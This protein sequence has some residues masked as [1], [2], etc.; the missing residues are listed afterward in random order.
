V[1]EYETRKVQPNDQPDYE[2]DAGLGGP[3]PIISR[4]LGDLRFYASYR[5]SRDMLILPLS[6]PDYSS[7]DW[8]VQVSSDITPSLKLKLSAL[9][10]KQFTQRH[11]WDASNVAGSYFYP[12]YPNEVANV[13]STLGSVSDLKNV[14]SDFNFSITD[15]GQRSLVAKVT[16]ILSS[17]TFY[18]VSIENFQRDYYT[19]PPEMRDTSK[20]YEII[21]GFFEDSN[22]FGYWP[23]N[24]SNS[25]G[26]TTDVMHICKARDN[27]VT[28]ATTLK[29]DFTSQVNF[30]NLVKG[31]L[32]FV[33]NDL[34]F[35]YGVISSGT[36]G[37]K[38]GYRVQ[39]RFYPIQAAAY[40]QDKLE[41]KGFTINIGLRLDCND[42][43]TKWYN[44]NS[45]DP[46][47]FSSNYTTATDTFPRTKADLQWQLSPRIGIAHPV[48]ENSKLFFNYGH[49]R[50]VPQYESIFRIERNDQRQMTSFGNPSLI[51]AKTIS[52]ELGYDHILL[53]EYLVQLA[54]FY[55]DISDQQD[56]TR[57]ISTSAGFQYTYSTP[58]NYQD[59]RGFEL[60]LRK[61]TGNWWSG[62]ANYTYQVSTSGHFNSSRVY[63]NPSEQKKWN[64][65]TTNLY[66]DRPIPQPYAR[67]NLSL[68]TPGDFGPKLF[69]NNILGGFRVNMILDWQSGF[70]TT[71][72]P[73]ALPSIGYN[74]QGVDFFNTSLRI[75]K[76]IAIGK[77]NVQLFMDISN[78]LNALRLY[79]P[80][81][82][83]NIPGEDLVGEYR[84]PGVEWQ[85]E[86]FQ[87]QVQ[88]QPA[89]DDF[90]AIYFEGATGKYWKVVEDAQQ[91]NGRNWAEVDQV[92][93][94]QVNKDKAYIDMPNASIFWFVDPRKIFF[95]IRLSFDFND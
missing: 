81:D 39:E 69:G 26:I 95:G 18:E 72:N 66:Q 46:N 80:N 79:I 13:L 87:S 8:T 22:P 94:D 56:F 61:T 53:D 71:W 32:E 54:A 40:L 42:P 36:Q 90:R 41:A 25:V 10:G 29:A 49:F 14:F 50:Q 89:P 35:D 3:V 92:T 91:P 86:V 64:E 85:P 31:G 5:G 70:W 45:F 52:Y 73:K 19:R 7:Y 38:Y 4:Y 34:D 1:F 51:L 43:N 15:I 17:N 24:Y 59:I 93:I 57:Y 33:Y 60:T 58:N 44:V 48:S 88:G 23:N 47:F 65:A 16:G 2:I 75:D 84:E 63:D 55:N 78:V 62:F 9:F 77:F 74:V 68:Y 37:Q 11:N 6:R 82:Q 28:R 27:T 30:Q 20:I 83:N 21:P 12:R 76:S 67:L